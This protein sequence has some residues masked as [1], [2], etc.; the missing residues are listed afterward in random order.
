MQQAEVSGPFASLVCG[1]GGG[2]GDLS[3]Y[4][5]LAKTKTTGMLH[6]LL[7]LKALIMGIWLVLR[8]YHG[9]LGGLNKI[10]RDLRGGPVGSHVAPSAFDAP[11]VDLD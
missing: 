2:A 10:C 3:L 11:R 4:L 1:G 6:P 8:T 5:D 9:H 7:G